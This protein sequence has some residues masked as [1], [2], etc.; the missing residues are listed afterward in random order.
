MSEEEKKIQSVKEGRK[1]CKCRISGV[2][3]KKELKEKLR[4]RKNQ[5]ILGWKFLLSSCSLVDLEVKVMGENDE[6]FQSIFQV[7]VFKVKGV[8]C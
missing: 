8:I 2:R 3:E 7:N 5:S 1:K 6:N 4:E